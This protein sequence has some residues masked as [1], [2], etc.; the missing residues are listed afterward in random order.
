MG[1]K[2]NPIVFRIG[3]KHNEWIL[4]CLG[5]NKEESS[6]F[7][8][9]NLEIRKYLNTIFEFYG[10]IISDCFINRS[11]SKLH[12]SVNFLITAKFSKK[13]STSRRSLRFKRI[14]FKIML[15]NSDFKKIILDT[16]QK[17][18]G[19]PKI[20]LKFEDIQRIKYKKRN[21]S[22]LLKPKSFKGGVN[23]SK[24]SVK[25][26]NTFI[27]SI[28]KR[29]GMYSKENFFQEAINIFIMIVLSNAPAELLAKFI[30]IQMQSTKRHNKFL[31]F[32]KRTVIRFSKMPLSRIKG[33]KIVIK[34]RFNGAPR[35][36]NR[37]IQRGRVP[38]QKIDSNVSYCNTKAFTVNGT[39][40]IKVWICEK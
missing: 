12:I 30:I 25:K 8:Y 3:Y 2:V 37:I 17:F 34:G 15:N 31:L 35:S 24:K 1:Q 14:F 7:L 13:F 10:L 21:R 5:K 23:L 38:L 32:L 40:G 9:Q 33:I 22:L 36:R 16:I 11:E 4:K 26:V 29:L 27:Y 28:I 39:F 19:I 18:T 6:Y 20:F